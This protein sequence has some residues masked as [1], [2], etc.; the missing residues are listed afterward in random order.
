VRGRLVVARE[1]PG[2]E[3]DAGTY[4]L[5]HEALLTGWDTL[6]G[7]LAGDAEQRALR[8][9]LERA[10]AEWQR[11]ARARELL[12]RGPQL[13][14][15]ARLDTRALSDTER[16]FLRESRGG[17]RRRR[18]GRV[19][20]V[21]SLPLLTGAVYGGVQL[22]A[23]HARERKL[24]EA[25]AAAQRTVALAREEHQRAQALRREAFAAFDAARKQEGEAAWARA[26]ALTGKV[27][28]TYG[29]ASAALDAALRGNLGHAGV[30]RRF[31]EVLFERI[32]LAESLRRP[33]LRDELLQRLASVDDTGELR[34]RL[35][36]PARLDLETG[37]A[38]ATVRVERALEEEG[39]QRRWSPPGTLGTTPLEGVELPPGSYRLT[40]Q[41]PDRPPV[42]YPVLLERGEHHPVRLAL[43]AAVPDG[44]VYVPPGRFLYGSGD[45]ETIRRSLVRAQPLH[46]LTTDGYLIGRTEVTHAEWL[47]FLRTLPPGERAERRPNATNYYGSLS[48]TEREPGRWEFRLERKGHVY[49]A[50]EGEPV[51]YRERE[52]RAV[53]DW[54]RFPVSGVSW[55]DAQAYVT[56]LD[57]TGRVR[58]ARLCD[59]REWERAARGAD[60]RSYP[61]GDSLEPDDAN[62]DATYGRKSLAF[63]PD[64]V[65]SHPASDS[66]FGLRD[67]S[68]NVWEWMRSVT[69]PGMPAYGGG[70]FYQDQ[71]TARILQ[72]GDGEP[73]LRSPFI[74]LRV[75]APAPAP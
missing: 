70:S 40:F 51:H 23:L 44:F 17:V 24:E 50:R 43:P 22:Q 34:R 14:E 52:R 39:G 9:R 25:V 16:A 11:L 55:E 62:F 2:G 63:G 53:Q 15:V 42:H 3:A 46:A 41:L 58:G 71:F 54:L 57:A 18:L 37:P 32:Q 10:S 27:E 69:S 8:Q 21:L 1:A 72:H 13:A 64:E 28:R 30:R 36:A 31:A 75:C 60:G 7:W 61:H 73:R 47:A 12:W 66:P 56:W 65:G 59:E 48:V 49:L 45:E 19:A 5:A 29:E 20:A 26:V 35:L 4:E 68:G 67:A 74:G 6:R 33:A 38:G